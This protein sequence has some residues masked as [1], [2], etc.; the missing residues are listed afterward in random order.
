MI[1]T[2][3]ILVSDFPSIFYYAP[4][5]GVPVPR[6]KESLEMPVSSTGS[7]VRR[8]R[9]TQSCVKH[10]GFLFMGLGLVLGVFGVNGSRPHS[11]SRA[12]SKSEGLTH[13]HQ[14]LG[15]TRAAICV[16]KQQSVTGI[17]DNIVVYFL[18]LSLGSGVFG[19]DGLS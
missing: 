6:A 10:C 13:S 19:V 1:F 3:L 16:G 15:L 8:D 9:K 14:K 17:H 18:C 2:Y 7:N 4:F 11:F 12:A 5:F